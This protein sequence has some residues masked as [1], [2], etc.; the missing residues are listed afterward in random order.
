MSIPDDLL[1]PCSCCR[2]DL[3]TSFI[4]PVVG[5]CGFCRPSQEL[6]EDWD[7]RVALIEALA[8]G[9]PPPCPHGRK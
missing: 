4:G 6:L 7:A 3:S 1:V 8:S 2:V 9:T 5:F